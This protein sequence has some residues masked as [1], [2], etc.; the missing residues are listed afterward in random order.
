VLAFCSAHPDALLRTCT[1]A[2][3]TASALVVDPAD[4]RFVVLH[5]RKLGRWLQPGGHADGDDDLA[6][7]ALREAAEETGLDG[8]VVRL[9]AIDLDVHEVRPPGES[10]H[11]HLDLRF[12]VV[13]P[14]GSA[15]A[16]PPP[17]NHESQ[18]IRW[19]AEADLA[20]LD[21]DASLRRLVERARRRPGSRSSASR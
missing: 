10:P 3:L 17:G 19:V 6:A 13:A 20:A 4:G 21:V 9:P 7:V 12:V 5:H 1:E 18:E 2:H 11:R 16:G 14:P 8:L 15:A